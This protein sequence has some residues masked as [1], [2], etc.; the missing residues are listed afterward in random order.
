MAS[1]MLENF[2]KYWS[3]CHIVMKL[4]ISFDL[5]YKINILKFYF[6]IMHEFEALSE[7]KKIRQI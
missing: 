3:R 7:I 4:A 6:P 5:K 1:S 2:D